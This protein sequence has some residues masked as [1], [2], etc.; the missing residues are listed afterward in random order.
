MIL[1]L[2]YQAIDKIIKTRTQII[3]G[4]SFSGYNFDND[5]ML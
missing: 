2:I 5:L 3:Y 4:F 1:D